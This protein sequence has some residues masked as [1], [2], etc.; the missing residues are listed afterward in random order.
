MNTDGP[1]H[2]KGAEVDVFLARCWAAGDPKIEVD[3][4]QTY[5]EW[6]G[7]RLGGAGGAR[8]IEGRLLG[9]KRERMVRRTTGP[10]RRSSNLER[11]DALIEGVLE[12]IESNAFSTLLKGGI[13]RHRAFGYGMLLLRTLSS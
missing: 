1:R 10:D 6:L 3:R 7:Q 9:F 13:G 2:R 5:R 8:L 4:E 11:P 12:V